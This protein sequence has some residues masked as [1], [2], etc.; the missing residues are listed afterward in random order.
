MADRADL[1]SYTISTRKGI[2]PLQAIKRL[3]GD[4][5]KI[6]FAKGCRI[7]EKDHIDFFKQK[8][9]DVVLVS[10]K[11]N[12]PLIRYAARIARKSDIVLLFLGEYDYFSGETWPNH[13]GD[14]VNLDLLGSQKKLL[15]A[16]LKT[17]KPIIAFQITS[18]ARAYAGLAEQVPALVQCFYLGEQ[19]GLAIADVIFGKVNP[20]GKLPVTLPRSS[21]HI[22]VYYSKLPIARPGYLL[23]DVSPLFPF[24]HGLSY[25][26][27]IYKNLRL[28]KDTIPVN[29]RAVFSVDVTN[30]GQIQ[31][32]ETVQLYIHD[33]YASIDRPVKEL[34]GF[35]RVSLG[36]G[37]TKSVHFHVGHEQ[38]SF[39]KNNKFEVEPGDFQV[40][41]GGSSANT[42]GIRLTVTDK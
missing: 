14:K 17:G 37:E 39:Y 27:Y 28:D 29:G 5:I 24:G 1:G 16:L 26:T 12:E 23:D 6:N 36:P 35:A 30:T 20:S 13:F 18:G 38:L 32:T 8:N 3:A 42:T 41:V 33:L 10:D 19:G 4:D 11:E 2:T 9:K 40:M 34:K 25:T 15:N 31:G 21:G 22:P 7:G